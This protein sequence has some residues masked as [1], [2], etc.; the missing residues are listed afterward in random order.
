MRAFLC[1]V[2]LT[3]VALAAVEPSVTVS[4]SRPTVR[5]GQT[6]FIDVEAYGGRIGDIHLPAVEGLA[7][8]SAPSR[9]STG[10]Q[11][12]LGST[13]TSTIRLGFAAR[14]A[15]EG[16]FE[17]PAVGVEIDGATVFSQPITITVAKSVPPTAPATRS[18]G[19][20]DGGP[21]EI[22][23][24]DVVFLRSEVDRTS[25]YEGESV[26]LTLSLWQFATR[27]VILDS[28]RPIE[29]T[30][31]QTEGFYAIPQTPV[32]VG[33]ESTRVDGVEYNVARWRQ[34]L[35]P[36]APGTLSIDSW[37]W[38]CYVRAVT[39]EGRVRH[40]YSLA[41][42]PITVEVRPLPQRP[43]GF[44]GAVGS[45]EVRADLSPKSTV[46][47]MP[48]SLVVRIVGA[49]NPDAIAAPALPRIENVYIADPEISTH[50]IRDA[51][52][53][54]AERTF[55]YEIVPVAVGVLEIPAFD[56]CYFDPTSSQYVTRT[57]GPF[58]L[59]VQPS[60][61]RERRVLVG[62]AP[63][64]DETTVEVLAQDIQPIVTAPLPAF[65]KS[66]PAFALA[67]VFTAPVV[68]YALL[69]LVVA[70]R[71]RFDRD[72]AYARAY[73]ARSRARRRLDA[74]AAAQEPSEE[75]FRALTGYVADKL[76]VPDAGVTSADARDLLEA[77]AVSPDD[78]AGL[79]K[80]LRTCERARYA[81]APLSQAEL[82]AL[83]QGAESAL[84]RMDAVISRERTS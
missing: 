19:A 77:R 41:T 60:G 8:E 47:N 46:Q 36:T 17:I 44:S 20:G 69:A 13:P 12:V 57:M 31:P 72:V 6:F 37:K 48:V 35:F 42:E 54:S 33:F 18:P 58:A 83:V 32:E 65:T 50:P 10:V 21:R 9:R 40:D 27:G 34:I 67:G 4:V 75:V 62:D 73:H 24:D 5:V 11:V 25:V 71:R 74:A 23:W 53:I 39:T 15:Q 64:R 61:E 80:I 78:M 30:F 3:P 84:E 16:T 38:D 79:L 14:A 68:F 7:I 51:D 82:A 49:G 22:G 63:A 28:I 59:D 55:T 70:R 76:D 26:T 56:F 52:Q 81:S 66:P 1:A 45:F 43:P 2:L 29:S